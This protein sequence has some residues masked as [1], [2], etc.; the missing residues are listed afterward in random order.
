MSI[1]HRNIQP[2]H[3][4][5]DDAV[6]YIKERIS[7]FPTSAMMK[8]LTLVHGIAV[9]DTGIRYAHAWVEENNVCWDAG[10]L[11]G[12]RIWY[13]V[14]REEF[15]KVRHIERFTAYT[16]REAVEMEQKTG[17]TCGPW[18]REYLALCSNKHRV[19]GQHQMVGPKR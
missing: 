7:E 17:V 19:V 14:R 8:A 18:D 2:T 10:I 16:V 9:G 3:R 4:C 6:D 13:S 12:H 1:N 15:Y 5:F 11:D